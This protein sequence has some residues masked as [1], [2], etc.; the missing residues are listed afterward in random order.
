[1]VVSML[2]VLKAGGAC[3]LLDPE[4]PTERL[5]YMVGDAE[6]SVLLTNDTVRGAIPCGPAMRTVSVDALWSRDARVDSLPHRTLGRNLSSVNYTFGS[7]GR[8]QGVMNDHGAV[9]NLLAWMQAKYQLTSADVVLQKTPRSFDGLVWAFLWP[10]QHGA[11]VALAGRDDSDDPTC[12]NKVADRYGVTTLHCVAS[13]LESFV[14]SAHVG[15]GTS[16]RR[17]VCRGEALSPHLVAR[18]YEH[19]PSS[20]SLFHSYGPAETAVDVSYWDCPCGQTIDVVPI[21]QPIWN[22]SLY[23]LDKHGQLAPSGIAGELCIGGVHVSRGYVGQPAFTAERFVPD[24]VGGIG[25]GRLHRT[26]DRARWRSDGH[27][28]YLG[29]IDD[30]A[31]RRGLDTGPGEMPAAGNRRMTRSGPRG[32][33]EAQVAQVWRSVLS[34][35]DISADDNFFD[36]GGTSLLLY[37][38]HS[39]L[40]TIRAD[41]KLVDLF[42]YPTVSTLAAYLERGPAPSAANPR[43]RWP[44]SRPATRNTRPSTRH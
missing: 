39:Q 28:E 7:T 6:I 19:F 14:D 5:A 9:A 24:S 12:L 11:C 4:Y 26:G 32:D 33:I 21:G 42:R 30:Q 16:L 2:A 20:V 29:R 34:L 13:M 1:M 31:K 37:R 25:G 35:A 43:R 40:K 22:T 18:F 38:V 15:G 36:I 17:V 27:L 44:S 10:L 3:V 23:V 8:P 41:L